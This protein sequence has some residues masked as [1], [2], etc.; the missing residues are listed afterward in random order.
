MIKKQKFKLLKSSNYFDEMKDS[1]W[2]EVQSVLHWLHKILLN[3]SRAEA[4]N[5]RSWK[6]CSKIPEL[7]KITLQH[8][9]MDEAKQKQM[10]SFVM[11]RIMPKKVAV[12]TEGE[13]QDTRLPSTF[14]INH[15]KP[16]EHYQ[17][18]RWDEILR[19]HP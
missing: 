7:N 4:A 11:Q 17:I 1:H 8:L 19:Q 6:Y 9:V 18:P 12:E 14:E 2:P 5:E 13:E 16:I 3:V 10:K 15:Q